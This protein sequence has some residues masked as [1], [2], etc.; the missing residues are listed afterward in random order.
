MLGCLR[1]VCD[2]RAMATSVLLYLVVDPAD[3]VDGTG[4]PFVPR[5]APSYW[6]LRKTPDEAIGRWSW[7]RESAYLRLQHC[8]LLTYT[9]TAHGVGLAVLGNSTLEKI[10][11]GAGG[12]VDGVRL[13]SPTLAKDYVCEGLPMLVLKSV[14]DV[15]E[16]GPDAYRHV[17]IL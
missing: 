4:P 13:C 17:A 5:E 12:A 15:A 16:L 2:R 8:K 9:L 14:R 6:S 10:H 3:Y 1:W 11:W 7:S